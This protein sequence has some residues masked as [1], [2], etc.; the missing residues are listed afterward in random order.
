MT[1]KELLE[2]IKQAN[3]GDQQALES[4]V[5]QI[6]DL[7]YNLALKMLLFPEDAQDASQ[8]I[9][10]KVITR[11]STFQGKSKFTT[12]V[13]RIA[14]NH[15]ISFKGKKS[16]DFKMPFEDY[17]KMI[18][19][20]QSES[21]VYATN[22]GELLLLEEEVKVSCTQG[23]LLCLNEVDRLVYIIGVILDFN[24]KEGA[25]MLDLSPENFRKKRSRAKDKLR[26]FM[27][28]K[29]GLANPANPCRCSKKID[30]LVQE[31]IIA[32]QGL[33]FAH[34]TQQ[35]TTL[36]QQ[37]RGLEKIVAI[38]RSNPNLSAPDSLLKNLKNLLNCF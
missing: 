31:N 17:A 3:A 8:D 5:I 16:K 15:L 13:Y 22:Q 4:I 34:A 24:S 28:Q 38:Y 20:G 19:T 36:L 14:S 35:S 10:I 33:R 11:L 25:Y 2:L 32:P 7:V 26:H 18:D 6:K 1:N 12:W 30:F 37:I 23:L 29:C 21:S 9:L 27:N